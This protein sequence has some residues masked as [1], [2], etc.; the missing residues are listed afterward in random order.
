MTF[1]ELMR[2]QA[3]STGCT[4]KRIKEKAPPSQKRQGSVA[5][6]LG[7]AALG[8]QDLIRVSVQE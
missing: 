5:W 8:A 4:G 2:H 3:Q 1:F 6:L 7:A